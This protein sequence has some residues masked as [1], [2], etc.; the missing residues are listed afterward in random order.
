ME[1]S[2]SSSQLL[3]NTFSIRD[4]A[5]DSYSLNFKYRKVQWRETIDYDRYAIGKF[6][7]IDWSNDWGNGKSEREN[8]FDRNDEWMMV[9]QCCSLYVKGT[10]GVHQTKDA[11]WEKEII[12][13]ICRL[14]HITWYFYYWSPQ[15]AFIIIMLLIQLWL[16]SKAFFQW[17]HLIQ[18]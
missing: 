3:F 15:Q 4:D 9:I 10:F 11:N 8:Y 16:D 12:T 14:L 17:W 18:K 6:W 1:I 7:Y 5:I 2:S 13:W